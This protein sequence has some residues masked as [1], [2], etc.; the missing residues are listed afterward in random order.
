MFGMSGTDV[1][2]I[3]EKKDYSTQTHEDDSDGHCHGS[4]FDTSIHI[5]R[6]N[7]HDSAKTSAGHQSAHIISGSE[8]H[9]GHSSASASASRDRNAPPDDGDATRVKSGESCE[10][11]ASTNS[12]MRSGSSSADSSHLQFAGGGEV[13]VLPRVGVI[14]APMK[15]ADYLSLLLISPVKGDEDQLTAVKFR[16]VQNEEL[17]KKQELMGRKAGMVCSVW[18]AVCGVW[19]G[20]HGV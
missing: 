8:K 14:R 7:D 19:E 17:Q 6:D 20:K 11:V 3:D 5:D 12:M 2:S 16:A 4:S 13:G 10:K 9:E 1:E 18:C 15:N